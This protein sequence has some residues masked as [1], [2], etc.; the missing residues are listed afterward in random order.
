M[1]RWLWVGL[2]GLLGA[3]ARYGL[4]D[5][6]YRLAR[7]PAFPY[8]TLLVNGLG[9]LTIGFLA[10]LG[11][12]RGLFSPESR[13]LVFIGFLGAF[14]TFST[15]G[16]ETVALLRDGEMVRAGLNVGGHLVLAIGSVW[17]GMALADVVAGG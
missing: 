13:A 1:M 16:Y 5:L 14:T 11:E 6:V 2:G 17:G 15:F 4:D 7:E 9:C 12:H 3:W 10:T 8:G